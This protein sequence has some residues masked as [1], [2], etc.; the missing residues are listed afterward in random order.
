[1]RVR[2]LLVFVLLLAACGSPSLSKGVDARMRDGL[3]ALYRRHD[4]TAAAEEFRK[5]LAAD[6]DRYDA[7]LQLAYAL[8]CDGAWDDARPVW[9]NVARL[10]QTRGDA[11]TLAVARHFESAAPR[12]TAAARAGVPV[13]QQ[14]A[15]MEKGLD[16][17]YR[18]RDYRAAEEKFRAVLALNPAHYGAN[19][20]LAAALEFGGKKNEAREQ[21]RKSL[22]MAEQIRDEAT[23]NLIKPHLAQ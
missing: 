6:P 1:M 11:T 8:E 5:V 13:D 17:L 19:Y 3:D 10:A 14:A 15:L 12:E 9:A 2:G 21:W 22:V 7:N 4:T 18:T 20:Q 23:I 16:A